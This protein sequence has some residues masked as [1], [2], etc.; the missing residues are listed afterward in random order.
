[1]KEFR[2]LGDVDACRFDSPETERVVREAVAALIEATAPDDP[3]D[4]GWTILL[5]PSDTDEQLRE[6]FGRGLEDMLWE[7]RPPIAF[8]R[9]CTILPR[10][11]PGPL[12]GM[13]RCCAEATA[14]PDPPAFG[15]PTDCARVAE[16]HTQR[17]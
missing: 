6:F 11:D 9:V 1:M 14:A 13:T 7:G 4:S 8:R 2:S 3:R 5:E 16:R 12:P 15:S 10:S 17:T